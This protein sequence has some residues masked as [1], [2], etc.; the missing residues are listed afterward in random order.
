MLLK[1][2][3]IKDALGKSIPF[4]YEL[5]LSQLEFF[6]ETPLKEPVSVCG[7]LR[8]RAGAL[9]L[10]AEADL[11]VDT[12]CSRC[13]KPIRVPKRQTVH[14]ALADELQDEDNDEILLI[15]GDTVDVDEIVTEA[16]V[17]NMDFIFLCKDDCRGICPRCGVDLNMAKCSCESDVQD[18]RLA[19]LRDILKDMSK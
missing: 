9:E 17:L 19:V 11:T 12:V 16:I 4:S 13:L 1:L 6:G 2:K 14:R 3:E 10:I 8:N 18:E 7:E 15:T 5:D